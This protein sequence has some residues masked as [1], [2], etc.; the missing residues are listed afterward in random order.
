MPR[1]FP[2]LKVSDR[3]GEG[4]SQR[5]KVAKKVGGWGCVGIRNIVDPSQ[6]DQA[7]LLV[8]FN[9]LY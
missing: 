5:G 9:Y 8:F 7:F 6:I 1:N 4:L 2:E 3:L